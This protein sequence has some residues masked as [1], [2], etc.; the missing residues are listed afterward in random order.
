MTAGA[1]RDTRRATGTWT[2]KTDMPVAV[3]EV[4]VAEVNGKIYVVGGTEQVEG[5]EVASSL[6][7]MYDPATDRWQKRAALPRASSHVGVV[8]CGG[9]LY[10]IGGL[11]GNVHI[12]PQSLATVYDP[13]FDRWDELP[14]L[15]SPRGS[16]AV[17]AV[18]GRIHVIGGRSSEKVVKVSRPGRPDMLVGIG[19]VATHEVFDLA[20][21]RWSQGRP[22]PGPS[23]DHMGTAVLDGKIHAFGGR[24]NDY[25][26][27]L[28][29]HDVYDP[30]TDTWT[31]A[32]ALPRPR[33]AGASAVLNGLVI[34]AGGEC[35]PGGQPFSANAFEDVSAYDLTTDSWSALAPL[36]RARHAFGGA[37]VSGR[38][39]FAGGSLVCGGGVST[40][41]LSLTLLQ[42][43]PGCRTSS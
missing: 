43:A 39:Y 19:T 12:G 3:S 8:G 41:L 5:G 24:I 2:R 15:S 16:V 31:S 18:S 20:A 26:D 40:D 9:K 29:R 30:V 25:S 23:R 11:A 17:A 42:E 13:M 6:T 32:A 1:G 7:L 38:A 4:G 36:P 10:A 35:K 27:L 33:S 14:P 22:L 28:D 37:T 34:Y 21:G